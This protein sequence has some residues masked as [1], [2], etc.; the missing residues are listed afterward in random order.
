[1]SKLP[2]AGRRGQSG[3]EK[4][5]LSQDDRDGGREGELKQPTE[6]E[7]GPQT[8]NRSQPELQLHRPKQATHQEQKQVDAHESQY[9]R[10]DVVQVLCTTAD[11]LPSPA[12]ACTT[13]ISTA[14]RARSE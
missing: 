11:M 13:T 7:A 5:Q 14:T 1:M 3:D 4:G 9:S 6:T 12:F 10:R 2:A 8:D